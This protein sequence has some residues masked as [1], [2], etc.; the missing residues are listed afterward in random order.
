M[1]SLKTSRLNKLQDWNQKQQVRFGRLD[2]MQVWLCTPR[3]SMIPD[4]QDPFIH[5]FILQTLI[6][7]L[8]CTR[9]YSQCWAYST[10]QDKVLVFMEVTFCCRELPR[11]ESKHDPCPWSEWSKVYSGSCQETSL[12][13][14]SIW[15][16][17]SK[18]N[19]YAHQ[20][21]PVS[22]HSPPQPPSE[23]ADS[24]LMD[25][26]KMLWLLKDYT[27]VENWGM[28]WGGSYPT[29][30][31]TCFCALTAPPQVKDLDRIP[32]YRLLNCSVQ[33]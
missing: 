5:S 15:D 18:V 22:I 27:H 29:P 6:G 11:S 9:H 28:S 23:Y 26:M 13:V 32:A 3:Q 20:T 24:V 2:L 1:A 16:W 14:S 10:E 30:P 19:S 33:V 8:L 7:H 17:V 25:K 12:F 31:Y 21:T 4:K